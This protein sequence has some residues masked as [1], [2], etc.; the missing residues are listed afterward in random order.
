MA[1]V[2]REAISLKAGSMKRHGPHQDAEKSITNCDRKEE[3]TI[4]QEKL[5]SSPCEEG[6]ERM[7]GGLLGTDQ[8]AGALVGLPLRVPGD[9]GVGGDHGGVGVVV[10]GRRRKHGRE[11]GTHL[12]WL[13]CPRADLVG[14]T[15]SLRSSCRLLRES[16]VS[17]TVINKGAAPHDGE[18]AL[19]YDSDPVVLIYLFIF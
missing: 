11:E 13:A 4:D 10:G 18:T 9:H 1:S 6:R 7:R 16:L 19:V 17:W 15:V 2:K 12:A 14:L 3:A 8:L 5:R